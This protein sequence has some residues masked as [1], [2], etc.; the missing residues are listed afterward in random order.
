MGAE[1][2]RTNLENNNKRSS[3][4]L[5]TNPIS[6]KLKKRNSL[7]IKKKDSIHFEENNL[8]LCTNQITTNNIVQVKNSNK[9]TDIHKFTEFEHDIL[10]ST[11]PL[12]KSNSLQNGMFVFKNAFTI[13]PKL[14]T[15][16]SF[17]QVIFNY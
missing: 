1:Q 17:G 13:H 10:L 14:K 2:S 3:L 4:L 11:W 5:F 7:N 9:M 16:F 8:N 12:I 15:F 6:V